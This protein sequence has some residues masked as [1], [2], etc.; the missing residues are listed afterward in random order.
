MATKRPIRRN[1][2]HSKID[3]ELAKKGGKPILP[4]NPNDLPADLKKAFD[5]IPILPGWPVPD[6]PKR[7]PAAKRKTTK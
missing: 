3:E 1:P 2:A 5:A 4:V 6:K 7:K